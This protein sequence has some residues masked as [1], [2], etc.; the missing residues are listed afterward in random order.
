MSALETA[1]ANNE[2]L[3]SKLEMIK[4]ENRKLEKE[5]QERAKA[6]AEPEQAP[7]ISEEELTQIN[8]AAKQKIKDVKEKSAAKLAAIKQELVEMVQYAKEGD[9]ERNQLTKNLEVMSE[10]RQEAEAQVEKLQAQIAEAEAQ[11]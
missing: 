7:A 2:D 5:L 3:T 8:E 11:W 9:E 1:T 4:Q 10:N 6:I